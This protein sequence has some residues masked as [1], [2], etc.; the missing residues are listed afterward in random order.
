MSHIIPQDRPTFQVAHWYRCQGLVGR[1][2]FLA[3]QK[4]F[5]EVV[6]TIANTKDEEKF[7][8][9][10][11]SLFDFDDYADCVPINAA[12]LSI[13]FDPVLRLMNALAFDWNRDI[14][15]QKRIQPFVRTIQVARELI[16]AQL[17][18]EPELVAFQRNGSDPNAV[19]NNGLTFNHGDQV[20]VWNENHP[21]QGEVAWR[22]RKDRFPNINIVV[23]DLQGEQDPVKIMKKFLDAVNGHTRLVAFSEVSEIFSLVWFS[24]VFP[25]VKTLLQRIFFAWPGR[26]RK[27]HQSSVK[28]EV[29]H[30]GLQT[31][32]LI[33]GPGS[34]PKGRAGFCCVLVWNRVWFSRE[35]PGVY[36]FSS[37]WLRKK[38]NMQIRNGFLEICFCCCSNPSNDDIISSEPGLKTSMDFG[39]QGRVVQSWVR[40]IWG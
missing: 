4:R 29:C 35:L 26:R 28:V 38:K 14:S 6:T 16:A 7:W 1:E 17:N 39:G 40:I 33:K 32:T 9:F 25:S 36:Q 22:I 5:E 27:G 18:V 24:I 37:K 30:R 2:N 31:P 13:L 19:I 15:I 12:N 20:V 34:T 10:V 21:T 3:F 11:R 8:K 23:L